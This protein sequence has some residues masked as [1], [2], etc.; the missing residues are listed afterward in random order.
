MKKIDQKAKHNITYRGVTF[1]P[2]MKKFR[3]TVTKNGVYHDCGVWDTPLLAAK[4][5]DRRIL[6]LGL[7]MPLQIYKK[8]E[9]V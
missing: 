9:T 2:R 4:A 7:D 5:R 1:V 6:S 3:G 8:V